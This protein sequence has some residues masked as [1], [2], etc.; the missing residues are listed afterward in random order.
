MHTRRAV[1][2]YEAKCLIKVFPDREW[3]FGR[4]KTLIGENDMTYGV[5]LGLYSSGPQFLPARLRISTETSSYIRKHLA[6]VLCLLLSASMFLRTLHRR[7][8]VI[9]WWLNYDSLCH[10]Y[11][12]YARLV[13]VHRHHHIYSPHNNTTKVRIENIHGGLSVRLKVSKNRTATVNMK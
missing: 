11:R 6:E 1:K 5:N 12:H 13:G 7:V 8:N 2:T 9:T 3:N 4:L 10:N